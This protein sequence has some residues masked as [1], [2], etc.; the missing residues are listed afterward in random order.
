MSNLNLKGTTLYYFIH[1]V[2]HN[3][4][5]V[6]CEQTSRYELHTLRLVQLQSLVNSINF[7]HAG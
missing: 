5:Q 3:Y 6:I 1:P 4:L 2:F 7:G